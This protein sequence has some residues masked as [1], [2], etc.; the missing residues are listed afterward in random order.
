MEPVAVFRPAIPHPSATAQQPRANEEVG[1][2]VEASPPTIVISNP[3]C[4]WMEFSPP[5][6]NCIGTVLA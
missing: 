4:R 5:T 2:A 3:E 6:T 1:K